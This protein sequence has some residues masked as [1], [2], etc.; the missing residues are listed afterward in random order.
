M[1]PVFGATASAGLSQFACLSHTYH[2]PCRGFRVR[3][4]PELVSVT[5]EIQ[6]PHADSNCMTPTA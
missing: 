1:K 6:Y 4:S 3:R 5:S 2:L